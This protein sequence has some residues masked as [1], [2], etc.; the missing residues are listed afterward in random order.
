MVR[1]VEHAYLHVAKVAVAL[2]D[3]IEDR[4]GAAMADAVL[5]VLRRILNWHALRDD[6]FRSPIVR[7][8]A[9]RTA[10]QRERDRVLNDDELRN[11]WRAAETFSPP[12]GQFIR[13]ML[14]TA[15]RRDEVAD[16]PWSEVT[17]DLW[18]I[19]GT[20]YKTKVEITLPLSRA[21][22]KVLDELPRIAGCD[23]AFTTNGRAPIS[24]FSGFK[25][26]LD[27]ASGVTGWRFHDLRRTARSLLS[28]AGVNPDIAERCLGHIGGPRGVYD[29]HPYIDEMRQAFEDLAKQIKKIVS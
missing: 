21:A 6:N 4:C 11:V 14:L 23:Y 24:G 15:T 26:R 25:L 12:W 8:M 22:M 27:M 20:R 17:G 28:R 29:R 5:A 19:P 13:L 2:L 7:G 10:D 16:M 1:L 3:E 18:T 9:R